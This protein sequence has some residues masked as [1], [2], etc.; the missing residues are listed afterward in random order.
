MGLFDRLKASRRARVEPYGLWSTDQAQLEAFAARGADIAAPRESE[1]FLS[2]TSDVRAK[3]VADEL[4]S[5]RVRHELIE[6]SHDIPEWMVFVRG[7][8]P[9]VPDFLR[10]TVDVCEE[11]AAT[12]GG[13]FE[14]WAGLLTEAEKD[15]S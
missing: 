5:R 4:R 14:G 13:E 8:V 1:F 11:L 15:A 2:F 3:A 9:L 6:P 7:R 10:E 12:Y